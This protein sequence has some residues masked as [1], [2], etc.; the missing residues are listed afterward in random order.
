[1][2]FWNLKNFCMYNLE[3][4]FNHLVENFISIQ[5]ICIINRKQF[6]ENFFW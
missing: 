2:T 5:F 1:M 4:N 6:N 3:Y